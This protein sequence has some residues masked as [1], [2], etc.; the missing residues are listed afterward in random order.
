[1]RIAYIAETPLDN[2][3]AY[4][5]H[6]I[7]MFDYLASGKIIVSSKRDGICEILK[8]NHNSIIVNQ[9]DLKSWIKSMNNILNN[10]Y[11]LRNLRRNSILTAKKYTWDKR[12]A[13]I[14]KINNSNLLIKY[15]NKKQ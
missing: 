10:K 1:M 13:K 2:R 14:L 8:H 4:T 12:V 9:Y 11:N 6:V 7:K 5:H 15:I 3:S